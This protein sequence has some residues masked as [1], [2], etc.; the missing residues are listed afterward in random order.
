MQSDKK[1]VGDNLKTHQN[2]NGKK[3]APYIPSN[4]IKDAVNLMM[5]L[6]KRPLLLMGEP[7]CGKTKL[8]EAVAYD[9]YGDKFQEHY[10]EWNIK[11]TTKAKDGLYR[12]D[13]LKRLSD[14]QVKTK[15]DNI[16]NLDL[17]ADKSY[18]TSGELSKAFKASKTGQPAII[19]IDEIDKADLDF[20]NDLL[21]ELDKFEFVI[22]ETGEK[23]PAP[24]TM[25]LIFITSNGEKELPPAFLRRCIFH[26]IQ[27]PDEKLLKRILNSH[28]AGTPPEYVEKA[29]GDFM[30]IRKKLER[31]ISVAEK[32][33]STS[34]LID[35]FTIIN[36]VALLTGKSPLD[37]TEIQFKNSL[38]KWMTSE[39]LTYLPFYQV[40]LKNIEARKALKETINEVV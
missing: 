6:K 40:L 7:G 9:L 12:Y 27:F 14:A 38:D 37:A 31:T 29:V 24:E 34:E 17:D 22:E 25:P 3:I 16:D 8:A 13:A 28:F 11:S 39:S 18:I 19:L 26:Y 21:N 5:L 32:K 35:W 23:I 36:E 20:P 30:T 33:V 4:T 2:V 15:Q 1:Y 10:F